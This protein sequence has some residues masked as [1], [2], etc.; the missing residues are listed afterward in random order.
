MCTTGYYTVH[1]CFFKC[2]LECLAI[3]LAKAI[4]TLIPNKIYSDCFVFGE[5]LSVRKGFTVA[6]FKI[7]IYKKKLEHYQI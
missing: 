5:G 7:K 6:L 3:S 4:H 2:N 1:A